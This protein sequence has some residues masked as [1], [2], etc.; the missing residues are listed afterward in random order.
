MRWRASR[1]G[2]YILAQVGLVEHVRIRVQPKQVP[3]VG[4]LRVAEEVGEVAA[5]AR[6]VDPL[7]EGAVGGVAVVVD[8]GGCS[9]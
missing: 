1:R 6:G 8:G 9:C 3:H 7:L 4:L 5:A 2:T